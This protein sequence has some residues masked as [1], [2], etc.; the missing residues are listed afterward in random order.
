MKVNTQL[1]PAL[2]LGTLTTLTLSPTDV[3]A[4]SL[5]STLDASIRLGLELNTEPDTIFGLNNYG[6]RIRYTGTSAINSSIKLPKPKHQMRQRGSLTPVKFGS[7][8][9]QTSEK[10][11]RVAKKLRSM[12]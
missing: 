4:Q 7:V 9:T 10:L 6:S 11:R 2:A 1:L 12:I 3:A 5:E 8:L